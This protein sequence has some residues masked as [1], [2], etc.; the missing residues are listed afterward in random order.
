MDKIYTN[1][2][3]SSLRRKMQ[4]TPL[5]ACRPFLTLVG[6]SKGAHCKGKARAAAVTAGWGQMGWVRR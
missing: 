4:K 1:E 3:K 5:D 6:S 2:K